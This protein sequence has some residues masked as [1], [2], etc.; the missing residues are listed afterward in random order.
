MSATSNFR[1]PRRT[2][3]LGG[4]AGLFMPGSAGAQ[5]Y[6]S[7]VIRIVVPAVAGTPPDIISR[8]VADEIAAQKGWRLIVEKCPGA[9]QTIAM[10]EVSNRPPDRYSLLT[11][12]PPIKGSKALPPTAGIR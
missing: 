5:S 2:L 11:M 3:L 9:L 12:S 7:N 8:I 4:L 6:P 1:L 10:S